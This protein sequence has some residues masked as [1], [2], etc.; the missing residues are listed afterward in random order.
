M[1]L[2]KNFGKIAS[3]YK[4]DTDKTFSTLTNTPQKPPNFPTTNKQAKN[5][6]IINQKSKAC[7]VFHR[8]IFFVSSEGFVVLCACFVRQMSLTCRQW[9]LKRVIR[10]LEILKAADRGK[11]KN[12]F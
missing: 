1:D 3:N 12:L 5:T 9:N 8:C 11:L 7:E 6:K 4:N 10:G 2:L